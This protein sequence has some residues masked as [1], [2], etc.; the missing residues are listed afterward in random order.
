[1][2]EFEESYWT[3]DSQYGKFEDYAQ[4]LAALRVW[5]QGLLRLVADDLPPPGRH[6]DAGCGHGAIVHE[7]LERGFDAHGFDVSEWMIA[8]A[9]R[10]NPETAKRFRVGDFDAIPFEGEV[11]LITC[12]EVLEHVSEPTDALHAL[13]AR[14]RPGGR[15][16]AT[17]P[18]LHPRIPWGDPV[19]ADPTHVSVHEPEWWRARL[20][21]ADFEVRR[22]ETFISVPMLWRM[23]PLLARRIPLGRRTGPEILIV[24]A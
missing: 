14:L 15:L 10:A 23:H 8:Q 5:Y 20:T 24:A 9:K 12:L 11:D 16:I 22:L 19:A 21:G 18:N 6:L 2:P 4:A 3:E 13:R 1:V 17:T 7:L